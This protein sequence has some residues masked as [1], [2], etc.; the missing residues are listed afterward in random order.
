MMNEGKII[1][2]ELLMMNE[3]NNSQFSIHNSPLKNN[4]QS[5]FDREIKKRL[6]NKDGDK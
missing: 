4:S 2:D 1:N 3:G 6:A 5:D